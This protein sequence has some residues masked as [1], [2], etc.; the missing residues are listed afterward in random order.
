MLL[1]AAPYFG[2]SGGKMFYAILAMV[3]FIYPVFCLLAYGVTKLVAWYLSNLNHK[4][5]LLKFRI[6]AL[7]IATYP[8]HVN[9]GGY[10]GEATFPLYTITIVNFSRDVNLLYPSSIMLSGLGFFI[11]LVGIMYKITWVLLSLQSFNEKNK[12]S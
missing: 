10:I 11:G 6:I 2:V 12:V 9:F 3:F 1:L 5:L 8:I 7:I 4:F